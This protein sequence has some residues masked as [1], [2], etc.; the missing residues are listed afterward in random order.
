MRLWS[1]IKALPVDEIEIA[2]SNVAMKLRDQP[3]LG[4]DELVLIRLKYLHR[5]VG[6]KHHAGS[7]RTGSSEAKS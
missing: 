5:K 4:E 3:H 1:L 2:R 6:L 7:A